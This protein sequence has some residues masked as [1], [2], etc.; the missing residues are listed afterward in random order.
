MV[1]DLKL[2]SQ[3]GHPFASPACGPT[4]AAI[5]AEESPAALVEH[6]VEDHSW[7]LPFFHV[8]TKAK[9]QHAKDHERDWPHKH[10]RS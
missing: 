1:K 8:K 2:C 9:R 4:H 10:V 3:C 7:R 5:S 6:M